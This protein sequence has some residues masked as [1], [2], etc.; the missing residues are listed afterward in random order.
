MSVKSEL[1][2]G[3]FKIGKFT[4]STSPVTNA[5]YQF[6]YFQEDTVISVF[7][8]TDNSN[9]LTQWGLSG[10]TIKAGVVLFAQGGQGIKA[11]TLASGSA[12]LFDEI[13]QLSTINVG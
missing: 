3:G 8:G 11:L 12:F 5:K 10:K 4:D 7:T 6:V 13:L 1:L 9:Q 2:L